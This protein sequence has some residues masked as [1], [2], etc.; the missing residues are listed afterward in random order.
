MDAVELYKK[1]LAQ[2]K[3]KNFDTALEILDEVK[4]VAPHWKKPLLLKAYILRE[5]GKT[6]ELFLFAQKI[7][8]L[9]NVA[10]S[11]EKFLLPDVLNLLGIA[12]SKLG[13]A[14]SAVELSRFAGE[15]S[16]NNAEICS[17]LSNAIL[18]ANAVE[19]FSADDFKKLY[20]EYKKYLTDITPYPRKF[21]AHEKIRVGFL[22]ADFRI[23]PVIKWAWA[24]L[25]TLD[26]NSFETYCYIT[27]KISDIVTKHISATV[28]KWRDIWNLSDV[29]AAKLIRDDEIDILFDMSGHTS[30]NR[31]RVAA[32]RPASI[33]ISGI[34]YMNSTGLPCFDYFL[35]DK[36]C[37][38][39]SEEFFTEKLIRLPHSHIC[40]EAST[41]LDV[42]SPPCLKKNFV[43]F[44]SF[45]QLSKMT[46]SMLTA[47]KKILDSVPN[48]RLIIKNKTFDN[49]DGK[50]F[51]VNRL[52]TLGLDVTR[53]ELR[54]FSGDYLRQYDDVDIALDTFPY[55]GG[56]TTCEA[57]Y[58]GVPVVSLYGNRHGSRFGLSILKNI[59]LEELAVATYDD[60]IERAIALASDWE[61]LAILRKNLRG[62]MKN[63]P[64]MDSENYIREVE[65][66]FKKILREDS[67]E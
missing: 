58:M 18:A 51:F 49:D 3:A 23:H 4:I 34:G 22:S 60:Y 27:I 62:M 44:A 46:D 41:S 11:E 6:V 32:Y 45:N 35:S 30:G 2:F 14:E 16:K 15:T 42:S 29:E 40:Y 26:K 36:I 9:F 57:L 50:I 19:K 7:L 17:E 5:Q 10:S 38:Q 13:M 63:S 31:L 53:I 54:G 8:P 56:V 1:A 25:T 55:T 48:S 61:L 47:W 39:G 33:Q 37:A 43:T 24:L 59:G 66:A 52:N 20:A 64:L 12:C 28:D 65:A 21:Y 67:Y